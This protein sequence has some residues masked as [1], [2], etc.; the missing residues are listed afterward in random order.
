M[1]ELNRQPQAALTYEND[2]QIVEGATHLFEEPGAL[3]ERRDPSWSLVHPTFEVSGRC[4]AVIWHTALSM[5]ISA[6][7]R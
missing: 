1:V 4:I 2:L 5:A 7:R 6:R 3:E